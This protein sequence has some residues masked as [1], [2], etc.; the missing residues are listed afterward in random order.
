MDKRN[1]FIKTLYMSM[2]T[3]FKKGL[4]FSTNVARATALY[5][6]R[7]FDKGQVTFIEELLITDVEDWGASMSVERSGKTLKELNSKTLS[8]SG[9]PA[10]T[11]EC[12]YYLELN[13]KRTPLSPEKFF[14]LI[15]RG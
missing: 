13:G 8:G 6:K 9:T 1:N 15:P 7:K 3:F 2:V 11:A 10:C 14:K 5:L 4:H 12:H